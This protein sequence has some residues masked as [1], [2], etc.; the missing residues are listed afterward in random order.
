M[1]KTI[2]EFKSIFD[3]L[4]FDS[5]IYTVGD[6]FIAEILFPIDTGIETTIN[7]DLWSFILKEVSVRENKLILCFK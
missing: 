2:E 5:R 4:D 3:R 7:S 1:D 6:C